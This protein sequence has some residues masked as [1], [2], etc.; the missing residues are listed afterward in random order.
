MRLQRTAAVLGAALTALVAV[1]GCGSTWGEDLGLPSAPDMAAI[2]K[3]VAAHT[4]C[5]DLRSGTNDGGAMGLEAKDP[6]WAVKQRAMCGDDARD[7]VTLLSLSDM[8]KFQRANKDAAARGQGRRFL[9]GQDFALVAGD[10]ATAKALLKS[11]VMLF[12]CEKGFKVPD[13][14]RNEKPL[15]DGCALTDYLPG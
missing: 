3:L 12:T 14:Y 15:V 1:T 11:E 13:G 10:D 6:A 9:I 5:S 2:E 7:T 8:E 4:M